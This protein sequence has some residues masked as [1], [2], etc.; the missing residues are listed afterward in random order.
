MNR[1]VFEFFSVKSWYWNTG[2]L[3]NFIC[4]VPLFERDQCFIE[5][6]HEIPQKSWKKVFQM[7]NIGFVAIWWPFKIVFRL[8]TLTPLRYALHF[9]ARESFQTQVFRLICF[10]WIFII[11]RP[12][13]SLGWE[14]HKIW[15]FNGLACPILIEIDAVIHFGIPYMI[16]KRKL[17]F[18]ILA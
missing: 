5:N 7:Q 11:E 14:K 3:Y 15:Y 16:V 18:Q 10:S 6:L 17:S 9:Q 13:K 1:W 8:R 4:R 12:G 2:S